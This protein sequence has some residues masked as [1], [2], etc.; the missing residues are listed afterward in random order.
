MDEQVNLVVSLKQVLRV[1]R[2]THQFLGQY[3]RLQDDEQVESWQRTKE[4]RQVMSQHQDEESFNQASV[5]LALQ[6]QFENDLDLRKVRQ[7]IVDNI[8][9]KVPSKDR[10]EQTRAG[11]VLKLMQ[12]VTVKQDEQQ[13]QK[14]FE[15]LEGLDAPK[16][17][18]IHERIE[19]LLGGSKGKLPHTYTNN[20]TS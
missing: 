14:I 8:E 10:R 13:E 6:L 11:D 9:N 4:L 17:E 12:Q 15:M 16:L 7:R 18:R 5:K 2:L 20:I 19:E 3:E 1:P